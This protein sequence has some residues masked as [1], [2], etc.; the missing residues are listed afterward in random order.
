MLFFHRASAF[1]KNF[2]L[3]YVQDLSLSNYHSLVEEL[4]LSCLIHSYLSLMKDLI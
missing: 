4:E 2:L 3:Y 1:I